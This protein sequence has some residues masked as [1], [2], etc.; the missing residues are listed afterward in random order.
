MGDGAL[1]MDVDEPA[2]EEDE[3]G[4]V[5]TL[6]GRPDGWARPQDIYVGSQVQLASQLPLSCGV[7]QG[8]VGDCYAIG[9]ALAMAPNREGTKSKP[10]SNPAPA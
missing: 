8:M 6:V 3:N 2:S 5:T 1:F 9:M 4:N 7:E 10:D